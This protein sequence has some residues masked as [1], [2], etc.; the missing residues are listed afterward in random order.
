MKTNHAEW[1]AQQVENSCRTA[2]K[3]GLTGGEYRVEL[4]STGGR[5]F[6]S[7]IGGIDGLKMNIKAEEPYPSITGPVLLR[8][9]DNQHAFET[10][11]CPDEYREGVFIEQSRRA[12]GA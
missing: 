1:L 7:T 2:K 12:V 11:L 6:D 8:L 10:A 9:S 5:I 4:F 3:N